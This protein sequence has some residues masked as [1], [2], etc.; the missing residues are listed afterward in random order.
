ML[1][2][3]GCIEYTIKDF[4]NLEYVETEKFQW[5]IHLND[6]WYTEYRHGRRIFRGYADDCCIKYNVDEQGK[7][8]KRNFK[9][10]LKTHWD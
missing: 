6:T 5:G 9:W 1:F 4:D 7:I 2:L 10:V 8:I 3:V